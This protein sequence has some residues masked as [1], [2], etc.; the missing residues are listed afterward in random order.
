MSR[1]RSQRKVT[2]SLEIFKEASITGEATFV[3]Q[4][5]CYLCLSDSFLCWLRT[6]S[7]NSHS[8]VAAYPADLGVVRG[9]G[10][11]TSCASGGEIRR[12]QSK[13]RCPTG[14]GHVE[15]RWRHHLKGHKDIKTLPKEKIFRNNINLFLL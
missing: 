12:Y 8:L 7:F 5:F 14:S 13:A 6:G 2:F 9:R 4:L 3:T 1:Q 11:I 10:I 15:V